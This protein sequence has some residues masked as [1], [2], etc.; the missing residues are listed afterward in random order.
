MVHIHGLPK[1]LMKDEILKT[2]EYLGQYGT[3][4]KYIISYKIS[5]DT[6]KKVYSAYVT[7]SNELEAA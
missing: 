3:I 6:N 4:I 1:S 5:Q 2:D 7:Y